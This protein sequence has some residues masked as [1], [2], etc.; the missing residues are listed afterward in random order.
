MSKQNT[1]SSDEVINMIAE[2]LR[3]SDGEF[4]QDIANKVLTERVTYTDDS[5]FIV[6]SPE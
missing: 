6:E 3:Q 4:I 2:V 5:I 1:K